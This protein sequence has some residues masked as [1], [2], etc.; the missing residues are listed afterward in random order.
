MTEEHKPEITPQLKFNL[1]LK[2]IQRKNIK[3]ILQ[4]NKIDPDQVQAWENKLLSRGPEIFDEAIEEEAERESGTGTLIIKRVKKAHAGHHGGAWKV[5]YADF[6]TAMMAFFLLMWLVSMTDEAQKMG[7]ADYF[8]KYSLVEK[9]GATRKDG[10]EE[11]VEIGKLEKG[12]TKVDPFEKMTDTLTKEIQGQFGAMPDQIE[13]EYTAEGFRIQMMD[14]HDAP[15]F[16]SGSNKL[17]PWPKELIKLVAKSIMDIP[18]RVGI[19][20]Y[21][22][23]VPFNVKGMTNWELSALRAAAAR[24]EFERNGITASRFAKIVGYAD[25]RPLIIEDPTHP[26]NRRIAITLLR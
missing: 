1:V 13:L 25:R 5:A 7:I 20:G 15:M 21:T 23:S 16:D 17:K 19:E 26:K 8:E 14:R 12:E 9:Y 3:F 24:S 10:K 2:K 22:D 18:A 4:Q 6:V 11:K